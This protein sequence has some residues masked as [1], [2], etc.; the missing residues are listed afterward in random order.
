VGVGARYNP[1]FKKSVWME[2]MLG[3][4]LIS[5]LAELSRKVKKIRLIFG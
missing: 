3:C 2:R 1:I 5:G 4:G